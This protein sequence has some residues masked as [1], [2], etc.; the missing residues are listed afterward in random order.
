MK[1][2]T[3]EE[4]R[5]Y[6]E[7]ES[8]SGCVLLSNEYKDNRTKL[9][10]K[11]SCGN[12]FITTYNDFKS[13]NK[14]FCNECGRSKMG[15]SLT[16]EEFND[17]VMNN[18]N[19]KLISTTYIS[20]RTKM[21]FKCKCGDNFETE[22][23]TFK[24]QNK[25]HCYKCGRK[26]TSEKQTRTTEQ[27]IK[28]VYELVGNE[29]KILGNYTTARNKILIKHNCELC[30]NHEFII[31]PDSFLRGTRCPKCS[32]INHTGDKHPMYNPNL[33]EKDREKRDMQN[34]EIRKW[35]KQVYERDNYT[36]KCCSHKG[37]KLNAH[38]LNSWNIY[39]ETRF[40]INN[41]ITLCES[42]HKSF[43]HT[44]GYGNN[45]ETQFK[46]FLNNKH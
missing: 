43:H 29:Y 9:T 13:C 2:K 8:N 39:K 33:T 46:I 40:D 38:H 42:C 21:K 16:Y 27:F 5:N 34:G 35:T 18:S 7:I 6:I 24:S 20:D 44:Y 28:E 31:T 30:D 32:V 17:F 36:C 23:R 22:P 11:C 12:E 45:T 14:R 25:R 4:I 10:I 41:G 37:G 15:K 1:K 3:I 19:C 26:R